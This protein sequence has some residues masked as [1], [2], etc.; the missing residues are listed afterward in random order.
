VRD[1][2]TD[3]EP[4]ERDR[5]IERIADS[6]VRRG[7]QTPAILFLE[8]HKPLSYVASQGV[9]V[10]SPLV[11]PLVGL[12]NLQIASKLM[13]DRENMELLIQRIEELA[14]ERAAASGGS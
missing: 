8:M 10:L 1:W 11:A 9:V 6:V 7:M 3:L 12:E 5:I 13:E 4:G 2:D 14:E